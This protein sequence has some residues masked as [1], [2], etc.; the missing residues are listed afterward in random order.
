M[1]LFTYKIMKIK[2]R[3]FYL[4]L[5][6]ILLFGQEEL[7]LENCPNS[8]NSNVSSFY[9]KYF[10]CVDVTLNREFYHVIHTDNL[11]PHLSWYYPVGDPNH[12][13]FESQGPGYY[14][15]PN[16]IQE[17]NIVV[18]I[19]IDPVP[20]GIDITDFNVDGVVGNDVNEYGM[21][22][23]G[24]A[25]DGVVLYNPLAAPG[26][27]IEDEQYSFDYY[28]GHPQNSGMYH[29]HTTTKGPLEVLEYKGLIQNPEPGNG[30]IELYGIMCDG[31]VILGCT[32]L[33]GTAPDPD[34]LDAQNG[35]VHDLTDETGEVHFTDR[36]HTHI[37]PGQLTNHNFTPELM[38]Y[39]DCIMSEMGE[40]YLDTM[41]LVI[42]TEIMQNPSMVTDAN[43]EWFEVYNPSADSLNLNG[44]TISDLDND[45]HVIDSDLVIPPFE[46]ALL[47]R[48]GNY[49]ENGG[50][51]VDYDYSGINL[52]N[53][54]DE[55]IL[56]SSDGVFSDIV[57]WD[58][59]A[60]FPDPTG[61]SM[62]LID[63]SLD[64]SIGSNWVESTTQYGDGDLGTPGGPNGNTSFTLEIDHQS[65]WNLVGSPLEVE[66]NYYLSIFPDAVENTLFAF[67]GAYVLDSNLV[68][69]EG[70]WLRFDTSGTTTITGHSMNEL[71]IS[72]NENWNLI[73][74]LHEDM[75]IYS[76][77]D[78]DSI[79]VPNTL[80]GFSGAYFNTETLIP[81]KGYWLRAYEAGMVT[82]QEGIVYTELPDQSSRDSLLDEANKL[83]INDVNLYFG[84][85]IPIGEELEFS[86]PPLPPESAF[87]V[88]FS[89]DMSVCET[90]NCVIEIMPNA[91]SLDISYLIKTNPDSGMIWSLTTTQEERLDLDA[92]S[93]EFII[94][95]GQQLNLTIT[96]VL[97]L[98][99]ENLFPKEFTLY[100]NFP[101]PFNPWATLSYELPKDSDVNLSIY[102][103][104]GN[105]IVTLINSHQQAG[106]R[107]VQWDATDSNGRSVSAGVYLYQINAGEFVQTKKMVLLK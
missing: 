16:S 97:S 105:E 106:F 93:G 11:P 47:G 27:D 64:N 101:N 49:A 14:Q 91:E 89:G 32:E 18:S 36:Y 68:N 73:S 20:R 84:V 1:S 72:L 37:C 83:I 95:A 61:A 98:N 60:T 56:I 39:E 13:D 92:D 63:P 31:T 12:I 57:V 44:W 10:Q 71:S 58:N 100:P 26:D 103:I 23:R 76:V 17:Q 79:I 7:T 46:Y 42:I 55:L 50:V 52:A 54:S 59:G 21:G 81:G 78:P 6:P 51:E 77:I 90:E 85:E 74:G 53:G 4:F 41:D 62:A 34:N 48:N 87:D 19:P 69:G 67:D 107:T 96:S 25:L 88:R 75:S 2:S 104:L 66:D 15:N 9:Q 8:I 35:H 30:E 24:V 22:A 43:G 65:D 38:Y 80:F 40:T 3:I 28:N 94:P 29:Y 99:E 33:D 70:Y 102:D 82:I 5:I 86:L 45:N